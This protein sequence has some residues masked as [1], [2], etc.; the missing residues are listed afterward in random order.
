MVGCSSFARQS[1]VRGDGC[2]ALSAIAE[3]KSPRGVVMSG[4]A[5]NSHADVSSGR[6][7]AMR[8]ERTA[9]AGRISMSFGL[10]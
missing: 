4:Q 2:G 6:E 5:N 7:L 1:D 8:T 3:R 10:P 9:K